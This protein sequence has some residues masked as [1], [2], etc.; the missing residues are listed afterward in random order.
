MAPGGSSGEAPGEKT[1]KATD[2]VTV[3]GALA[4]GTND[5]GGVCT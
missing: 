3:I 4:T 2:T 5:L 1:A